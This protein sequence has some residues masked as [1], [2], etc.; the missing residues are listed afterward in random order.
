SRPCE[1]GGIGSSLEFTCTMHGRDARVTNAGEPLEALFE[2]I[3]SENV[4]MRQQLQRA[5][6]VSDWLVSPLP[7]FAVMRDWPDNV[8]PIG[9]AAAAIEPVGGEGMGLAMRSAELAA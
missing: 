1:R 4:A 3:A 7:R 5:S 8:I 2:E 6:R 9:N